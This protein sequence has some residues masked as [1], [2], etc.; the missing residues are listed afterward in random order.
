MDD[1]KW[2]AFALLFM[3]IPF[4]VMSLGKS[5]ERSVTK[6]ELTKLQ[7]ELVQLGYGEFKN[8]EFELGNYVIQEDSKLVIPQPLNKKCLN[9]VT[10]KYEQYNNNCNFPNKKMADAFIRLIKEK[11]H[12]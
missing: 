6:P 8:G 5:Y 11:E 1:F 9:Y 4:C 2:F 7:N 12:E 3:G 10:G